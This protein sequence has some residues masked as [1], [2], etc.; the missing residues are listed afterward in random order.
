MAVAVAVV[1]L[2]CAV[3]WCSVRLVCGVVCG[4]VEKT[5]CHVFDGSKKKTTSVIV[6]KLHRK[7]FSQFRFL[8]MQNHFL[9]EKKLEERRLRIQLTQQTLNL[10]HVKSV[11][12]FDTMER[13]PYL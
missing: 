11:I 3:L 10:H 1:V 4:V 13:A 2:C 5:T 12:I 8:L 6:H 7:G 9:E